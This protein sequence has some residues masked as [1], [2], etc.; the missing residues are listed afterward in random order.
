MFLMLC[1]AMGQ[2][3]Y[4]TTRSVFVPKQIHI[5][6][7]KVFA[8]DIAAGYKHSLILSGIYSFNINF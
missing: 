8:I 1:T 3:G 2:L 5:K 4:Y 6:R 7:K